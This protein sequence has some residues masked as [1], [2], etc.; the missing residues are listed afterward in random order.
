MIFMLSQWTLTFEFQEFF[1]ARPLISGEG[2]R[3][4]NLQR[5]EI[6]IEQWKNICLIC[7]GDILHPWGTVYRTL[8]STT[9]AIGSPINSA[10]RFN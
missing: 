2:L 5:V 9:E 3:R 8:C 10:V 7:F 1:I 6:H 4:F